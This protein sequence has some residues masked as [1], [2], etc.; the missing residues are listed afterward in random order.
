[1]RYNIK[2][3]L[4]QLHKTQV[5]LIEELRNRGINTYPAQMS[6]AIAGVNRSKAAEHLVEMCDDIIKEWEQNAKN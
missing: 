6:T 1:M 4:L 3:R 2:I 5:Q